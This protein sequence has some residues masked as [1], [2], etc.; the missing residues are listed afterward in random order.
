M[1]KQF[2]T[3][4]AVF[5]VWLILTGTF[6]PINLLVGF[7]VAFF[8]SLFFSNMLFKDPFPSSVP[9]RKL[10]SRAWWLL[11]LFA[12]FLVQ[13]FLAALLVS[14]YA[15]QLRPTFSPGV[16]RVPTRLRTATVVTM[17]ANLITLTPGTLT[18]DYNSEDGTYTIHWIDV[19]SGDPEQASKHI[20]GVFEYRVERIFR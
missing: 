12:V 5:I 15:F 13:A 2:L 7:I 8:T 17:L 11:N 10:F 16:V 1:R 18:L 4:L 3:L 14:R 20:I 9:A 19:T 6:L